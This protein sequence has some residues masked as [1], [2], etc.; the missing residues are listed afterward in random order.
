MVTNIHDNVIA[1]SVYIKNKFTISTNWNC[2]KQ[3]TWC[4]GFFSYG[5]T[6][7]EE[8]NKLKEDNQLLAYFAIS[9][10]LHCGIWKS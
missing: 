10:P 4:M 1:K 7:K 6:E 9:V 5:L 8:E 3:S 2:I